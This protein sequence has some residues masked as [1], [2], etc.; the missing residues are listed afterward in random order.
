MPATA[1]DHPQKKQ[2][3]V[4]K[5]VLVK[6]ILPTANSI[7]ARV[8]DE[9]ADL[10]SDHPDVRAKLL[11]VCK[12]VLADAR[13]Q[14]EIELLRDRKGMKCAQ[15]LSALEDEII[16]GIF[17]FATEH[18]FRRDNPSA[19][20][21]ISIAAVGGYGRGTL[22]PG[23]DIDLLFILPYKQTP[24]GEQ[25]TEFVLYM[26]WDLGQKVGHAVRSVNECIQMARSDFTVRTATLESRYV[27]GDSVLFKSLVQRFESEIV[28]GT[29][30]E[31][32]EAKLAERDQRHEN[33]GNT[34]Y[35]VEP[36]IK[37]G[38]GGLRDLNTLFWIGKYFYQVAHQRDLV[39]KG[40]FSKSELR[41][42]DKAE[43]FLWT[44][45]CNLHFLTGRAEEKLNFDLQPDL[46]KRLGFADRVG[47]LSVERFMKRY[48]LVAKDVGD[49]TRIICASLEFNHAKQ[50][51]M[52][53]RVF[54]Q[55]N[56]PNR[57]IK[58][59]ADFIVD[60]GR[61]NV[62]SNDVFVKDPVNLIKIFWVAGREDLLFHPDALKL[63]T[64][65]LV[66][67]R[68]NVRTHPKANAYFI[69]ILTNPTSA[70]R[71]LRRM[72]ESGVL[73]RF[74]PEFGK[75]VALMQFNMYHHYTVDEHLIRSIGVMAAIERGELKEQLPLTH[76]LLPTL[77]DT[78]LLYVALFI[79]DIAKGR[80]EDHSIAGERV[81]RKLCPRFGLSGSE[82][83]TVA[84]LVRYHLTMSE[85]AQSRDIQDPE[86][87][88][89]FA[90]IV[91]SPNRLA[92]L[93]I[94][95][96]CDIRAVGPGTWTGW[97]GSLLRALYYAT[98]PLLSGGHTQVSQKDRIHSLRLDLKDAL[99]GWSEDDVDTYLDRH[100]D[101]YFLR[102]DS[103][104]MVKHANLIKNADTARLAYVGE[105]D[106]HG[107]E[108]NTE[109]SFYAD[110]HPRLLSYI[111]AAC[112]MCEAS[113]AGAHIS[114]MRDGRALDTFHIRRVFSVD[115]D[116]R[117]RAS[118]IVE[119]VRDL[120]SGDKYIPDNLGRN[121]RLNKRL[122]PF[123]LPPDVQISNALSQKFTVIEASGLDRTGL[124]FD[125]TREISDL[126]LTI[127]SAH[128]GTY[129]EKAID[130]FYVTDL[131][132]D[133]I[134]EKARQN[135]VRDRLLDVFTV[136]KKPR[137]S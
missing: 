107:F 60:R 120:L 86:T 15:N 137:K 115:D 114:S 34:R 65:S 85:V 103:E 11:T 98:E 10:P 8:M 121:S 72:N 97:K 51:D 122:K 52:L 90:N 84:W 73:G 20:E 55:F 94:L 47:M 110:D 126:N 125:L 36:N 21:S 58:G 88:K 25:V 123:K 54:A 130:V 100:F 77:S 112:T 134:I 32:I 117:I 102:T 106:V 92:L 81:A 30:P 101:P 127:A 136:Q 63:L 44:V 5:P 62:A 31:F 33:I 40:V 12:A 23:S 1:A 99:L 118:R 46:A 76:E 27:V 42:F 9:S 82:T 96:A 79:H 70:E 7:V 13:A 71:I 80:P 89:N 131:T 4:T 116:E 26:L 43:K 109:I 135:R 14:T 133:K 48:F 111:A 37:E 105:C 28:E 39:G 22:A 64:R 128:I 132:G 38:K 108:S 68:A 41:T 18:A 113:I 67:L 45:R 56:R 69:K 59:E 53:G 74:V 87:A 66:S 19:S 29:G 3:S 93:M 75:I 119:T 6:F 49:L 17:K 24:W 2:A 35:V 95:T 129:G 83:E 50:P 78:R 91:Q 16:R 57:K 104:V 124:L 61:I